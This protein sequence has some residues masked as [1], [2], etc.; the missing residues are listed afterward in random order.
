VGETD[1]ETLRLWGMYIC[2]Y[3]YIYIYINRDTD[4]VSQT[5]VHGPLVVRG[6]PPDY[7]QYYTRIAHTALHDM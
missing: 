5:V 2:I 6:G 3:I 7:P 4:N 1:R